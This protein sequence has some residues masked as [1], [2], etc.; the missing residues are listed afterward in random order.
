MRYTL[1]EILD[2]AEAGGFAVPAFNVYNLETLMGAAHAAEKSGAPVIFQMYSRLF[3]TETGKFMA[4]VIQD[5]IDCLPSPA[6]F[7]LDHGIGIPECIRA[8]RYGATGVM[9]DASTLPLDENIAAT[10]K[11]VELAREAGVSVEGELG[12]IGSTKDEAWAAY[13]EVADA[14]KFV[15]ETGVSAL[16]IMVGTAHGKYKQAPVLAI[17]R[18]AE[19]HA[20]TNAHLV[21]HGGS[22]VPDDQICAAVKAGIR[23]INFGTDVCCAFIETYARLDPYA[24]PLD[25]VMA[26]AADA[27][28]AFALKKIR[29]LGAK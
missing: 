11:A 14:V 20:A 21:L 9:L 28:E 5:V 25:V 17:D 10:K 29:L 1:K 3:D 6:A 13:T 2:L 27:V 22:G 23:K 4:P 8:L 12:H 18:I 16:A 15:D 24:A 19:I 7:H 26:K